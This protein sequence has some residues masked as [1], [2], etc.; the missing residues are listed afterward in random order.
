[1]FRK[2]TAL[3]KCM[4]LK[5]AIFFLLAVS[6][7]Y[8][9]YAPPRQVDLAIWLKADGNVIVDGSNNVSSWNDESGNGNDVTA[10]QSQPTW[11]ADQLNNWPV[12]RFAAGSDT[13][14][15]L[16]QTDSDA[17]GTLTDLTVFVV[18]AHRSVVDGSMLAGASNGVYTSGV[19]FLIDAKN[20]GGGVKNRAAIAYGGSEDE[21]SVGFADTGYHIFD[22]NFYS[23]FDGTYFT[24]RGTLNFYVDT[25]NQS[26]SGLGSNILDLND[27]FDVGGKDDGGTYSSSNVDIAEILVYQA[28]LSQ[29]DRDDVYAYLNDKYF[30]GT[31]CNNPV[32]MEFDLYPDCVIDL[33][34]FAVLAQDWQECTDQAD[35]NCI[36]N[37]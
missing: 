20:D 24:Y 4:S 13:S 11:V 23:A 31:T 19:Y 21:L 6:V 27:Q 28:T 2:S 33:L 1:M 18:G 37:P 22:L 3:C 30:T 15:T 10:T 29:E 35:P 17:L 5:T 16:L 34:D 7:A 9:S 12:V 32:D 26:D 25:A 8:A 14:A 36:P